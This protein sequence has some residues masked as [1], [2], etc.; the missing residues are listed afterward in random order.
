L[1]NIRGEAS[2]HFR[3]KKREYLK[4]V[5]GLQHTVRARILGTCTDEY[6]NLR[7]VSKFELS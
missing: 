6:L 3:N 5:M 4:E 2:R 1:N 7:W